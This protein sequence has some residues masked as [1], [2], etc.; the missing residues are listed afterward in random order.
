M[1]ESVSVKGIPAVMRDDHCRQKRAYFPG[2]D[3]NVF[4]EKSFFSQSEISVERFC[5]CSSCTADFWSNGK[6]S[7]HFTVRSGVNALYKNSLIT[8]L[9]PVLDKYSFYRPAGSSAFLFS[10]SCSRDDRLKVRTASS[11]DT[12]NVFI[13]FPFIS[14]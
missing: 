6:K 3:R 9:L 14:I 4:L 11:A 13:F 7:A 2:P 5:P 8:G 1:R 12:A 10:S